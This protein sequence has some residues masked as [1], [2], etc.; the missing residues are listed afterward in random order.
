[1]TSDQLAT[2]T[3]ILPIIVRNYG[4]HNIVTN[5]GFDC[6]GLVCCDCP[7]NTLPG[8]C[9]SDKFVESLNINSFNDLPI[10]QLVSDY[11]EAFI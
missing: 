11:P 4:K 8:S 1:M 3:T 10:D 5:G 6:Y 9:S 7:F 2:I